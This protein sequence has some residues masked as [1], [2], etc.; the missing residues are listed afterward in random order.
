VNPEEL[1]QLDDDDDDMRRRVAAMVRK[2]LKD[3]SMDGGGGGGVG[4]G[5]GVG[6]ST[7]MPTPNIQQLLLHRRPWKKQVLDES[8]LGME[9]EHEMEV[10]NRYDSDDEFDEFEGDDD[11]PYEYI[12]VM[13]KQQ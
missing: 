7:A 1:N 3:R 13:D 11:D 12:D 10:Y 6:S 8:F 9:E 5:V 2:R 4:V